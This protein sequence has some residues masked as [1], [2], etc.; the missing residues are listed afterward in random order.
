MFARQEANQ[1]AHECAKYAVFQN[2]SF[3]WVAGPPAFLIHNL[4]ADCN[5]VNVDVGGGEFQTHSFP[6][7]GTERDWQD[8]NEAAR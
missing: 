7:Q 6:N 3:N 5:G 4:L 8:F 1:A 2:E